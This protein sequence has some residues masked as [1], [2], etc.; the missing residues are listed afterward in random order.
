MNEQLTEAKEVVE[1]SAN[2]IR[3]AGTDIRASAKSAA[4]HV[5]ENVDKLGRR[6]QEG[7]RGAFE[8]GREQAKKYEQVVGD[9]V[10]TRPFASLLVVGAVGL[11]IGALWARRRFH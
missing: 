10:A 5:M 1:D 6:V 11:V 9:S 4:R 7:A 2:V 3:T 8:Q